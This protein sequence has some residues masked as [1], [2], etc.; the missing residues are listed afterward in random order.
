M[1]LATY[2]AADGLSYDPEFFTEADIAE[3]S[4]AEFPAD[5]V[6]RLRASATA[7]APAPAAA[8]PVATAGAEAIDAGIA[9]FRADLAQGRIEIEGLDPA[10]ID[11]L[12]AEARTGLGATFI[13]GSPSPDSVAALGAN[14]ALVQLIE[15]DGIAE[16]QIAGRVLLSADLST[17]LGKKAFPVLQLV[18][19]VLDVIF[20]LIALAG[21]AKSAW[22]RFKEM[23]D[24]FVSPIQAHMAA[25]RE[26]RAA[27]QLGQAL[28][29]LARPLCSALFNAGKAIYDKVW[30]PTKNIFAVLFGSLLEKAK[31]LFALGAFIC[32]L[33][34]TAGMALAAAVLNLIAQM[35][36]L[37]DDTIKF[38]DALEAA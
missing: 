37:V 5:L 10:M 31:A 35:I 36:G 30:T 28:K 32:S 13:A 6:A 15:K 4:A 16:L 25:L 2:A 11:T 33:F 38:V 19:V 27:G 7:P 12:A 29:Q 23:V 18:V 17:P 8:E 14:L 34:A 1:T 22:Q 21:V 24:G 26:A 9:R 20:V 3:L